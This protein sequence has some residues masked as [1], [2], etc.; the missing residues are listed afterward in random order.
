MDGHILVIGAMLIDTK[1]VPLQG[2]E[3][4]TSNSAD[5]HSVRGGT[6]RNVAENLGALG[7][8]VIL[9]SAVGDD[10]D[11]RRLLAETA[12]AGVDVSHVRIVPDSHTGSYM[13][14]LNDDGSLAVAL[15]DTAVMNHVTPD[16]LM[17]HRALFREARIVFFDGSVSEHV[18][19]TVFYLADQYNLPVGADPSSTRLVPRLRPWLSHLTLAVP[20]AREAAALLNADIDQFDSDTSLALAKELHRSGIEV[21]VVTLSD[22]GLVY[23]TS[24]EHG[25]LPALYREVVDSTGTGDAITAAIIFGMLE[26]LPVTDCMRLGAAAAGLTLQSRETVVPGLTLDLLYDNLTL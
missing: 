24:G 4:G 16:W 11:G 13:A 9:V 14:I 17:R 2:L 6:A 12:M 20:N 7:A 22:Y 5:I 8:D 25:H 10:I 15:N 18:V 19:Q 1:G 23:A 26:N 3:P 21:A